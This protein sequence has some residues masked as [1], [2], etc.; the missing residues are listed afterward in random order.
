GSWRASRAAGWGRSVTR[1]P[2][3]SSRAPPPTSRSACPEVTSGNLAGGHQAV[4]RAVKLRIAL[5]PR[6]RERLDGDRV[7][8]GHLLDRAVIDQE[9]ING[10]PPR[11]VG[12]WPLDGVARHQRLLVVG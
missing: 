5:S 1:A 2:N 3:R 9:G 7:E 8:P 4:E 12:Q 6:Q 10:S 11:H